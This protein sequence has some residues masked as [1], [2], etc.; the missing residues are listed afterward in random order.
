MQ[1]SPFRYLQIAKPRHSPRE[2]SNVFVDAEIPEKLRLLA[3]GVTDDHKIFGLD[4]D[5]ALLSK[6]DKREWFHQLV[7]DAINNRIGAEYTNLISA[8]FEEHEAKDVLVIDVKRKGPKEAYL[9]TN[10]DT[11]FFVRTGKKTIQL[12]GREMSD[13]IRAN[14]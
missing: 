2:Q 5:Y 10:K 6:P 7:T 4:A 11:E 13:Y 12:K 14:W 3:V 8:K 9:T 1:K